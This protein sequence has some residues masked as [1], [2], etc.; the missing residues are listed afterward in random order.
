M[1]MNANSNGTSAGTPSPSGFTLIELLVVIAII[2]ILAAM[3]LPALASAKR[4]AALGVC[5]ASQKQ[6]ALAWTQ[7]G[8][9]HSDYIVSSAQANNTG[10]SLW[11][12]RVQPND[13]PNFPA[14]P[15]NETAQQCYDD[16]GFTLGGLYPYCKGPDVIHCPADTR[17]SLGLF[18][19]WCSYSMVDNMNGAAAA[20]PDYRIHFSY[21]I[22]H[23]SDRMVME[24]ENDPR[25]FT[26]NGMT[27]YE[28][29][30]TWWPYS[31]GS[32][33]TGDAPNPK[34]TPQFDGMAGGGKV[35]WYDGPAAFHL[36][37][38]TFSFC[39]GHAESHKW[40]DPN[41]LWIANYTGNDK[42][43][44][45]QAKGTWANCKDDL[46]WVYSHIASPLWP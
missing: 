14:V 4:R 31:L 45:A 16:Y 43:T 46:Y 25:P 6:F 18:P 7:F 41:T 29:D 39:D 28:N 40:V 22:K 36:T 30:N 32:T 13:L 1:N 11:S 23:P 9:D 17:Y 12:W 20:S 15:V 8:D 2:A 33:S 27:V 3:L 34:A 26:A 35:G 10:D 42:P 24:E 5:L 37:G 38:A 19:A 21:Q 44:Q